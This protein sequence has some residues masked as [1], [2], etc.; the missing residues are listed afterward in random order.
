[1][2][3]YT[4]FAIGGGVAA[5]F[6]AFTGVVVYLRLLDTFFHYLFERSE[7]EILQRTPQGNSAVVNYSKKEGNER[8][9]YVQY[10][11]RKN[12]ALRQFL[13]VELIDKEGT[14]VYVD[15][16]VVAYSIVSPADVG[17]YEFR[18]VHEDD[19][20]NNI[21]LTN[22]QVLFYDPSNNTLSAAV[23]V[24]VS[25]FQTS[26][27][28]EPVDASESVDEENDE[29][30][31][32]VDQADEEQ[33][34]QVQQ[35]DKPEETSSAP[36]QTAPD[37]SADG[38]DA[39]SRNT[40]TINPSSSTRVRFS[41]SE[42]LQVETTAVSET[43]CEAPVSSGSGKSISS[44]ILLCYREDSAC[45]TTPSELSY[46]TQD[47]LDDADSVVVEVESLP[48]SPSSPS[49]SS[50]TNGAPD[51][52]NQLLRNRRPFVQ[53]DSVAAIP[54]AIPMLVVTAASS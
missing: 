26:S 12:V 9:L 5:F 35:D 40:E 48:V 39:V 41:F 7:K 32:E 3:F 20:E 1:M 13:E 50:S 37:S 21:V 24:P 36:Q 46:T 33:E 54:V 49:N 11:S 43:T 15:S 25:L 8:K 4:S 14:I 42:G 31:C 28:K 19:E 10:D 16:D 27:Q 23:V 45:S 18:F 6:A 51:V 17:V 52:E 44:E 34:Q 38:E 22:N 53:T 29:E 2:D 30:D 47:N